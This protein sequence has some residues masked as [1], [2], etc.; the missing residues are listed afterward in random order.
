[1]AKR[2]KK[3]GARRGRMLVRG[4]LALA[5]LFL[6]LAGVP[7]LIPMDTYRQ[8]AERAAGEAL[9]EP[10]AIKTLQL[11]LLPRP[12]VTLKG[13]RIGEEG[14]RNL[15]A[16]TTRLSF[17]L[18]PLLTGRLQL[19]HIRLGAITASLGREKQAGNL[20]LFRLETC[21]G[22]VAVGDEKVAAALKCRLY[23]G[24]ARGKALL[25]PAGGSRRSLSGELHIRN[26]RLQ[27]LLADTAA[28][29]Q[30]DGRVDADLTFTAQGADG[31]AL[32][33]SLRMDGPVTLRQASLG[34]D[35]EGKRRLQLNEL[36]ARITVTPAK[37][38]IEG[39]E[40]R[41]YDGSAV[42][43][44][45]LAPLIA[46]R[47][48]LAG[49]LRL[50]E[51]ALLPL[52]RDAM[53]Q[54]RLSGRLAAELGFT[55]AAANGR[56]LQQSLRVDGPLRLRDGF[57]HDVDSKGAAVALIAGGKPTG[58]LAYDSLAL[59]LR[60]RGN[61]VL[62]DDIAFHSP[63]MDANGKLLIK[64]DA[65]LEGQ[66]LVSGTG[67]AKLANITLNIAGTTEHPL[68][69]PATSTMVGGAVGAAVGG[70]V[71]AAVGIA[72]GSKAGQAV[73]GIKG[74]LKGGK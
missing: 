21:N 4:A 47:Q 8:A 43:S 74:L 70:P 61:T 41:L 37:L 55:I 15:T 17:A 73:E 42:F 23:G 52:L 45:T 50:K 27:P 11:R 60:L 31:K 66:L 12:G 54:E 26:I 30:A 34:L 9:K 33:Q 63:L 71:G 46:D 65:H 68:L 53:G 59:Q 7:L 1:M 58:D 64:A 16:E 49:R 13:V 51:V 19:T 2:K 5:L 39:G 10:V 56:L 35:G 24:Q 38:T 14:A 72:I 69:Y 32:Q 67:L 28:T 40:A 48:A 22:T 62:A 29:T 36:R 6:L 44:A 20:R 3:K 18:G 25:F 57:I